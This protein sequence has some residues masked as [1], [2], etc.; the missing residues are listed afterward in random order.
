MGVIATGSAIGG[1]L[2]SALASTLLPLIGFAWSA[3]VLALL[4]LCL[5]SVSCVVSGT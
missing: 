5:L 1:T 3:R 4:Y 2:C